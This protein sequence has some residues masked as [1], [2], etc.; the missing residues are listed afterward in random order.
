MSILSIARQFSKVLDE[1]S[2]TEGQLNKSDTARVIAQHLLSYHCKREGVALR[3][4]QDLEL[5]EAQR[6]SEV[7]EL[8]VQM[9]DE[10]T[11]GVA[12]M[13]AAD[14]VCQGSYV[15]HM[16]I[17]DCSRQTQ[18]SYL[19]IAQSAIHA[20]RQALRFVPVD[21]HGDQRYAGLLDSLEPKS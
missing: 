15:D 12:V 8:A 18:K 9:L 17:F 5:R 19:R 11:E 20:Y 13:A 21:R 7:A 16:T 1:P 3:R 2:P 4:L 10:D 14:I 6:F